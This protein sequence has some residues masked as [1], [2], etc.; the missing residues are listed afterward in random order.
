VRLGALDAD[1]N[2][3]SLAWRDGIRDLELEGILHVLADRLAVDADRAVVADA[4]R[5]EQTPTVEAVWN[6]DR[7]Q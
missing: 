1:R 6:V 2:L 5:E 7:R 4:E 3:G